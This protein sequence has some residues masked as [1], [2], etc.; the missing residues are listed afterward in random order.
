MAVDLTNEERLAFRAT[1][2]ALET[3]RDRLLAYECAIAD[4]NQQDVTQLSRALGLSAGFFTSSLDVLLTLTLARRSGGC[5]VCGGAVFADCEDWPAPLCTVHAPLEFL[6][7]VERHL[8]RREETNGAIR[9]NE[10]NGT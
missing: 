7:W 9:A 10:K 3:L 2:Q 6:N 4:G 1:E 5:A 8:K